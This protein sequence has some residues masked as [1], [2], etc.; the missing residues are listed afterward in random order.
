VGPWLST[1][2]HHA[3]LDGRLR[4]AVD[5]ARAASAQLTVVDAAFMRPMTL[6]VEAVA[7]AQLGRSGDAQRVLA[8]IDD[9]WRRE[10]KAQMLT[11]QAEGWLLVGAGRGQA[12]ARRC[13][14]AARVAMDGQH[15]VLAMCAAHDA[16]RIGH[17][18]L[19]LPVLREAAQLVEGPLV[20][21]L[22]EHAVALDRRDAATL[23]RLAEELPVL[24]FTISG[25]ES[26]ATA[27]RLLRQA[28]RSVEAAQ[29]NALAAKLV[30]LIDDYRTPGLGTIVIVTDRERQIGELAVR[31][32]R[33]REIAEEL[34][35]SVRTVDNHLAS[36]YR[37]LGISRRDELAQWFEQAG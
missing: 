5:D 28:G 27:G 33:N 8:G 4:A 37:K 25:A 21:A 10:T 36:L 30:G 6:G 32:W 13:A 1:R 9:P 16:A 14:R 23:V 12:G 20:Q 2:A 19:A 24:G 18:T 15:A 11:E 22:L 3:L 17:P 26:A 29:A 34:E 31:R 7:L 35:I